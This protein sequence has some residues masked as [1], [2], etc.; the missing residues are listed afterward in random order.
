MKWRRTVGTR[1]RIDSEF[2]S[3]TWYTKTMARKEASETQKIG[4][5]VLTAVVLISLVTVLYLAS[6]K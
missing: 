3:N 4:A 1:S 5:G 2:K 6:K